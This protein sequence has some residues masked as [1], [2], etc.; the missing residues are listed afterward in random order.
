MVAWCEKEQSL[1]L[2]GARQHSTYLVRLLFPLTGLEI[3]PIYFKTKSKSIKK[4]PKIKPKIEIDETKNKA[5]IRTLR[6]TK[7]YNT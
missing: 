4:K 2:V 6:R 7:T 1:S 5:R 3:K